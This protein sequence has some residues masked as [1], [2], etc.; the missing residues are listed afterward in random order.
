MA[1]TIEGPKRVSYNRPNVNYPWLNDEV[2]SR[3]RWTQRPPYRGPLPYLAGGSKVI[4][5]TGVEDTGAGLT[6][7]SFLNYSYDYNPLRIKAYDRL[8]DRMYNSA[9]VSTSLAE[10]NQ[11]VRSVIEAAGRMYKALRLLKRGNLIG[12]AYELGLGSVPKG[13]SK[14]KNLAKRWL[15]F[16][17]GWEPLVNDIGNAIN[18]FQSPIKSSFVT[19]SASDQDTLTFGSWP[20]DPWSTARRMYYSGIWVRYGVE[21][22]IDNPNLFLA[23]NMGFVNPLSVVWE[24]VPFSFVID[25][26]LNVGQVLSSASDFYG[27]AVLNSYTTYHERGY[28]IFQ[29]GDP[30]GGATTSVFWKISRELGVATPSLGLKPF[31]ALSWQRGATAIAL[32]VGGLKSLK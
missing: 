9:A 14:T 7:E 10:M 21:V 16:H 11:T 17:L 5:R 19:A 4:S 20:P 3:D 29:R 6:A 24:L 27:L 26:F 32:L 28:G 15:E 2:W 30:P 13:A 1:G 22:G 25:W 12:C 8:K 18:V 23:N 31:K